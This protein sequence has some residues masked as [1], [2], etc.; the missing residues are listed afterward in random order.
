MILSL[1]QSVFLKNAT[2]ASSKID[3]KCITGIDDRAC[4]SSC[5][6]PLRA[7]VSKSL[8]ERYILDRFLFCLFRLFPC[9]LYFLF[10][11]GRIEKMLILVE[12]EEMFPCP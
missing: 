5:L 9:D 7:I 12:A 8:R 3:F 2:S 11:F 4:N 1:N 10:V 6:P